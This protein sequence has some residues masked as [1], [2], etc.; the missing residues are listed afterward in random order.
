MKRK[1]LAILVAALLCTTLAWADWAGDL[2]KAG[3]DA[4]SNTITILSKSL[5]LSNGDLKVTASKTGGNAGAR[6]T[7][8]GLPK[9]VMV[10]LGAGT[11]GTTETT[12]YV[13]DSPTGEWSAVNA[14]TV[15][16]ASTTYYRVGTTS[17][18][19]AFLATAVAGSGV[20]RSITPDDLEADEYIGFWAYST[21]ALKAGELTLVLTDNG[22]ARTYNVPA[23]A[24]GVWTWCE[25]DIS[26]LTGGTGD[27]VSAVSILLSTAG[28]A[29]HGAFDFYVD[30]MRKWDSADEEALGYALVQD[31]V[32]SVLALTTANTG[33]HTQI[34]L[35]ENTNFFVAYRTGNDSLVWITDQSTYSHTALIAYQ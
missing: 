18:K 30:A 33:D 14:T 29:A 11:N 24:A 23:V 10:P 22:G 27:V 17:L 32:L 34:A 16:S 3:I 13:D 19:V 5:T 20:T 9:I 4:A 12:T 2:L 25:V 1:I 26:A 28:A 8:E 35:V 7:I 31:G 15:A 21:E 6:N